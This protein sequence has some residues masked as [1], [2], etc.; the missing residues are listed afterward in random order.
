[1]NLK[2][3]LELK[4]D[5]WKKLLNEGYKTDGG[6]DVCEFA[7]GQM[8]AYIEILKYVNKHEE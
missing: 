8:M 4:I 5:R 7:K 3:H 2:K 6:H 1:M